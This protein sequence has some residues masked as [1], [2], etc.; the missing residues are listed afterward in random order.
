MVLTENPKRAAIYFIFDKEGVIDDYI[1]YQLADL[2][3]NITF[4]HC[5]INGSL[6]FEGKAKLEAIADEVYVR[7]N[8]GV[9]IGAYKAAIEYIGWD[10]LSQYDELVLLNNTCFGPVYPFKECFDWAATRDLDFWS[11]TWDLKFDSLGSNSYLH[12][13]DK[14]T[15]YQSYFLVMRRPLLGSKLLKDFF[16][17]IPTNCSY[18]L[19]G[20]VFEYAF[21][22]YFE[23]RGYKGAIYC[24]DS[25]DYNYPLLHNPAHLIRDKRM[26]V[27]KKRSFFHHYTDVLNNTLG[28]V[29]VEMVRCI[30]SETNYDMALVWQSILRTKNLSDIVRCAQLN[31]VLARDFTTNAPRGSLSVGLVFHMY[32][33][34]LF[35]ENIA[36]VKNFPESA[37]VLITTNGE[38]KKATI[39]EKLKA[40]GCE[41]KVIVIE[42]RGRDVSSLLVGA[43]DFVNAYDLICFMHD[44]KSTH[45]Q[46]WN[47]GHSWSYK[48][49]ENMV[50]TKEY[51]ANV[52]TLFENE[53]NLGVAFPSYPNH[54]SYREII[55]SGWT[56]NFGTT[57]KLLSEFGVNAEINEHTLCVAPLGTCFWFRPKALKK[58]FAGIGGK[59]W[60]YTDF[61]CEPNRVDG[62]I[63][64]AI[65][66]SYAYFAQDAGYYPVF[67]YNDKFT[68]I[69]LT[70]LEFNKSSS[71]EMRG[72]VDAMAMDAIGYKKL[73]EVFNRPVDQITNMNVN[74]GVKNACRMLAIALRVKFPHIW[75]VLLPFRRMAKLLLRVK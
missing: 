44:K 29:T 38:P 69:E 1:T 25:D 18:I 70:N 46:P 39:E 64:H 31:R 53:R 49:N 35:D 24:D 11:L 37:G 10:K 58:L 15:H 63:L 3:E 51:V 55:G 34:D 42:S 9:D 21:P 8:K 73:E 43:A 30:E 62:T 65:E 17:D 2:R 13:N 66:R 5:V 48:L 47:V 45:V 40:T 56:M 61:P 23:D 52:I 22:G 57:Q 72:W 41:A 28:E 68:Q 33:E 67:I 27:F 75:G 32:Y 71:A 4:L 14:A 7:E 19:S 50:A 26:P 54:S 60:S 74:Y 6:T 36:F 16:G 20:C 12:Y 59:G